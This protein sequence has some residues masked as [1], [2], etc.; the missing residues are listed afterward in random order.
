MASVPSGL[1][2]G[3]WMRLLRRLRSRVP[4]CR[5]DQTVSEQR[6][7]MEVTALLVRRDFRGRYKHTSVG[8]AQSVLSSLFY[9]R[10][11]I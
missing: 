11:S 10:S 2:S 4:S 7:V 8:I 5:L 9:W 1:R 6:R 3:S